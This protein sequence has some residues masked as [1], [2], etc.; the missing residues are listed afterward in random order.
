M[1]PCCTIAPAICCRISPALTADI[2]P[3]MTELFAIMAVMLRMSVAQAG[4]VVGNFNGHLLRNILLGVN[5][6]EI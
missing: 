5:A 4:H 3:L 2:Q 1:R 6:G